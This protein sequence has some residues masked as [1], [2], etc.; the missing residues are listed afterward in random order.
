MPFWQF[1]QKLANWLDWP[2]L[3]VQPS[4]SAHRKWPEMVVSASTN[5]VWTKITIGSY[6]HIFCHSESDTSGVCWQLMKTLKRLTESR[7]PYC[8]I[9]NMMI[10]MYTIYVIFDLTSVFFC[11]CTHIKVGMCFFINNNHKFASRSMLLFRKS[12]ILHFKVLI[13]NMPHFF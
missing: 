11:F 4:I 8:Q 6:A 12:E 3:L 5:Q 9:L 1:Y 7:V 13:T 10:G 2:A